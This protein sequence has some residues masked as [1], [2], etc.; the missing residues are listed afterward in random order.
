M[1]T[2]GQVLVESADELM[3]Q[4]GRRLLRRTWRATDAAGVEH[5][6]A[7]G[8]F[9]PGSSSIGDCIAAGWPEWLPQLVI[10]LYDADVGAPSEQ[11]AADAW[12]EHLARAV[13]HPI[14]YAAAELRYIQALIAD[15]PMGL[16]DELEKVRATINDLCAARL[17]GTTASDE[18]EW[19]AMDAEA[20]RIMKAIYDYEQLMAEGFIAEEAAVMLK[21]I[22]SSFIGSFRSNHWVRHAASDRLAE[23]HS[24]NPGADA[25]Q[26]YNETYG[27]MRRFL[28]D[29]IEASRVDGAH[30]G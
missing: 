22:A 29:A 12:F 23:C 14:D 21:N 20:S 27:R 9:V 4:Y 19:Q 25:E 24:H 17:A 3:A 7:L 15:I 8:A 6:C 26:A 30:H 11:G 16:P 5:V 2:Q 1:T 18:H 13:E 28:M 10:A